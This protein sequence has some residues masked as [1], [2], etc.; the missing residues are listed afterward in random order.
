MACALMR[1]QLIW[2]YYLTMSSLN[3]SLY[4]TTEH[5]CGYLPGRR[6]MNLVP[7]P[8][9]PM[10]TQLYSQLIEL[11]Y[12]RSGSHTYRPHCVN[13]DACIP[14]RLPVA[15]FCPNRSQRRCL[16]IND[17]CTLQRLR[18]GYRNEHFELYR[19]YINSRHADGNMANPVPE[20]YKH[21]L[22][23]SW[24]DT[25]FLEIREADQ[26]MA[27]AVCDRVQSGLS[28]VYSFF[29][30]ELP[31]RSLG[32]YCI[33]KMIEQT[34]QLGANY[35]YLGYLILDSDKMKY[36]QY[37]RPLEVLIGNQWQNYHRGRFSVTW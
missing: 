15:D 18:A 36:K 1:S 7:D 21:F 20:D 22:Y 24:S 33:L 3:I 4:L 32:T 29:R 27:V 23:S 5:D 28:A 17:K 13:C 6:A 34:Q 8:R 14:C 37:F 19:R 25:Y 30:P 35:L 10:N 12:R 16:Q 2:W 31:A 26:L 11:G 9:V